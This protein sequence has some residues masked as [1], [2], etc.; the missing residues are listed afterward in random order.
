MSTELLKALTYLAEIRG[1]TLEHEVGRHNIR[2]VEAQRLVPPLKRR[3][4]SEDER[5]S[6]EKA[7]R[8][9]SVEKARLK[10]VAARG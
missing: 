4:A 3:A 6:R 1:T 2:I 5:V 8:A 7:S 10:R 9:R